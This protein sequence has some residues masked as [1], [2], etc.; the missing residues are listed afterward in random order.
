MD[1]IFLIGSSYF[2]NGIQ[3]FQPS[4]I[5][6]LCLQEGIIPGNSNILRGKFGKKD[7]MFISK[8]SKEEYIK[9]LISSNNPMQIGKFL[10]KEFCDEIGFTIEDL[11]KLK[12]VIDKIDNKHSY[13]KI[14]Y[15]SY[16]ENNGFYLTDEQRYNA[17]KIYKQYR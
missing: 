13:E 6:E 9:D 3:N 16:I 17:Y 10:V 5:D 14:I 1:K 8:L 12:S 11:K 15:N 2:F 4:D 7:I